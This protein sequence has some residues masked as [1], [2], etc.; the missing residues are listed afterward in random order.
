M[1]IYTCT[2]EC[3]GLGVQKRMSDPLDLELQVAVRCP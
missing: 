1:C 2:Y 3:G